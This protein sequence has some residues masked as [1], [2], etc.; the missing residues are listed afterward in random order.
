MRPPLCHIC[1]SR[2]L[3]PVQSDSGFLGRQEEKKD[4]RPDCF[5]NFAN[6]GHWRICRIF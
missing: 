5:A 1:P 4:E 3:F 2:F 6:R